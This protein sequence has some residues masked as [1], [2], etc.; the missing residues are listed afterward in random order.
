VL[1]AAGRELRRGRRPLW[2]LSVV[3]V[4]LA[5][6]AALASPPLAERG[7]S[8]SLRALERG[9][10]DEA[11][12]AAELARSLDPFALEPVRTV[13]SVQ[14]VAGDHAAALRTYR[15]A[16]ELQPENPRAWELLGS[17]QFSRGDLCAA[18]FSLNEAYTRDPNG[19]QWREGGEL[20]RARAY[21]NAGRCR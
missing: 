15:D 3:A 19:A 14:E 21:V 12:D 11:L 5:V 2:A 13:A 18:Y 9:D 1:G 16:V 7:V 4:S 20:D 8:T 10:L 6:V 17:Y